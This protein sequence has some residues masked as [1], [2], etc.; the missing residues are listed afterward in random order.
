MRNWDLY[1]ACHH[2]PR[3]H[4]F[5]QNC[6]IIS[7]M[8]VNK[9]YYDTR[10]LFSSTKSQIYNKDKREQVNVLLLYK[11]AT[12]SNTF[13]FETTKPKIGHNKFG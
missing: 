11:Y 4:R 2:N 7:H 13:L 5:T 6:Q 12:D 8:G 3:F 9:F 1:I 10:Y